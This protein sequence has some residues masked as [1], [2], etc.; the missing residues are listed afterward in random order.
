MPMFLR[1]LWVPMNLPALLTWGAVALSLGFDRF[2]GASAAGVWAAM[3]V[4]AIAFVAEDVLF[5]SQRRGNRAGQASL[6]ALEALAA[7]MVIAAVQQ[8]GI[9][10]ALSVILVAQLGLAYRLHT[11]FALALAF[12]AALFAL[13]RHAQPQSA[14]VDTLVFAG[15]QSFAA[16]ITHYARKAEIARDRLARVNADLLATRALFADSARDA[17]SLRVA[18]E[19]HDVAGH[20]LTAMRLNLRA[21]ATD[22]QFAARAEI[23]LAERLSGE[24]LDDIRGVVQALRDA[25]GF[26]LA[27]ALRALAAPLPTPALRL[28]IDDDVRVT[29]PVRAEAILRLV[30]EALTNAAR[31]S[32]AKTVTVVL[33]R[34][35][36]H[37]HLRIED[38]GRIAGALREGNGV[39]GM[40]ERIDALHG[41][42][43]LAR[44]AAGALRIDASLPA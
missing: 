25:R 5:S 29:D 2:D 8:G 40:R 12:D 34:D 42:F 30:Q 9:A 14:L 21:L 33:R 41:E 31:H 28:A 17:E 26:D 24:L 4:F 22:P 7:C 35:G 43:A 37:L 23:G 3:A 13:L 18:R 11:V 38:D 27:T 19:L 10:P 36:D 16:L 15:F 20:K 44:T 39:A 6:F 1:T 32:D